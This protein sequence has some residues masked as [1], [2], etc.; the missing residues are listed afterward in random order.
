MAV[1]AVSSEAAELVTYS[2]M[3]VGAPAAE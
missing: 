2:G 3:V 1:P